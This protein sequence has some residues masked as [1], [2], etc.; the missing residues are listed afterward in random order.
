LGALDIL[1]LNY[2][3]GILEEKTS[4]IDHHKGQEE[5]H[6]YETCDLIDI[7]EKGDL[8]EEVGD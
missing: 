1:I 5:C 4:E 8:S 7:A 6:C 2:G 3:D